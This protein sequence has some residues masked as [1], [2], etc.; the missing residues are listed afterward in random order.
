MNKGY[1]TFVTIMEKSSIYLKRMK[2]GRV[3][4]TAISST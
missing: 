1:Q 3:F 2:T 4:Y